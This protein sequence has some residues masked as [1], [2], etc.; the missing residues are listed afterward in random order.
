MTK[1]S[2]L[3]FYSYLL[4]LP[5]FSN[6]RKKFPPRKTVVL[7][8]LRKTAPFPSGCAKNVVTPI[9]VYNYKLSYR[10]VS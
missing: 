10:I 3:K 1:L 4:Y 7:T 2:S 8:Y 5:I 9:F 6:P